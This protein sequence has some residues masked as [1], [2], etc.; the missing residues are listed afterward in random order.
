MMPLDYDEDLPRYKLLQP[1][2]AD[3]VLWAEDE[4]IEFGGC[5]NEAMEPLNAPARKRMR[6]FLDSLPGGRTMP[7]ADAVAAAME[8]R[9]RHEGS[10][11]SQSRK[12]EV[13]LMG[14]KKLHGKGDVRHIELSPEK[15]V[16]RPTRI[17]GTVQDEIPTPGVE[18]S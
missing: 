10:V 18:H 8:E 2:Y 4:V 6:E 15:E 5:P 12:K 7:L 14:D 9:P 1:F 13:S 17:M 3:D 11:R 16:K